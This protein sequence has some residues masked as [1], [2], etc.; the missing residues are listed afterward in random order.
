MKR[1]DVKAT[2]QHSARIK[3]RPRERPSVEPAPELE[4]SQNWYKPSNQ[5]DGLRSR[6]LFRTIHWSSRPMAP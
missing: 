4:A 2:T 6:R 3:L 1:Y 5:L